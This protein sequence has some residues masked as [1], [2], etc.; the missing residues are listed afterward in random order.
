MAPFPATPLAIG[1][2]RRLAWPLPSNVALGK[3]RRAGLRVCTATSAWWILIGPRAPRD[4]PG[5][6][7]PPHPGAAAAR[8]GPAASVPLP[9]YLPHRHRP[10]L[11]ALLS[12]IRGLGGSAAPPTLSVP[13]RWAPTGP[14]T[15]LGRPR[16]AL[17]YARQ[18]RRWARELRRR[19]RPHGGRGASRHT[20]PH[21][22]GSGGRS[23][24]PPGRAGPVE[25]PGQSTLLR[26]EPVETRQRESGDRGRGNPIA[27]VCRGS[28]LPLVCA[29]RAGYRRLCGTGAHTGWSGADSGLPAAPRGSPAWG[30]CKAAALCSGQGA[31]PGAPGRRSEELT[32]SP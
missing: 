2:C 5:A 22:E 13:W 7:G 32:S 24:C 15:G 11:G 14:G 21:G 17:L 12:P 4:Q 26:A 20:C 25:A 27:Q 8:S 28:R 16:F 23:S 31:T 9:L 18:S 29:A 10:A 3:R 6:R 30:C 1:R 19:C